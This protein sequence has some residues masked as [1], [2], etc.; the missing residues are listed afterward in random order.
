MPIYFY[1]INEEYGSF[2]NFSPHPIELDGKK[3]PTTEHY[4]QAQKF[5]TT[6]PA[7]SEKIR[8]ASSPMVAARLGRS[9]KA[10]LRP[11][12][13]KIKDDVMR[14]A[15]RCKV[16]THPDVKEL[17]LST[18]DEEIIEKTT[19]DTY[20]GCGSDGKGKNM[21]GKILMEI[22]EELRKP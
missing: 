18:G 1:R 22:R 4:F 13:E 16:M 12:W 5:I 8:L 9:R 21:L 14:K 15:V 2:S 3:W 17:L 20:W 11:D 6:D 19:K 10:P 7:Y